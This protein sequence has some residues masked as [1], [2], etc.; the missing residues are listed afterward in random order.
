MFQGFN[1]A[2]IAYLEK[3]KCS[4]S[5]ITHKENETMF[6]EGIRQP[7][8]ELYYELSPYF[9][10]LDKD[11]S[12]SKGRCISSAYNDARFNK[13][14][15][16]KEYFYLKFKILSL[17]K[18]N[19]PGFFL[20]ASLE[21]YRYGLNIYNMDAKG[22][23]KIRSMILDNKHSS[24]D[25]IKRF[26]AAGLLEIQG[27]KLK[28]SSYTEESEVLRDWLERKT[29]SFMRVNELNPAFFDRKLYDDMIQAFDSIRE[30]YELVKEAL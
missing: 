25:V 1:D 12:C 5:K 17:D 18:K 15:P 13:E 26:N 28:R 11:F 19:V 7:L 9:A 22:M 21:G 24:T 6:Y 29:I 3:I 2:T 16:I 30:V 10:K 23:E 27:D 14:N 8:E 4:N 20:D